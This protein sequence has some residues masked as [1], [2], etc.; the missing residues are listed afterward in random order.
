MFEHSSS[1]GQSGRHPSSGKPCGQRK[2]PSRR[3]GGS[4]GAPPAA[5]LAAPSPSC[6]PRS[7]WEEFAHRHGGELARCVAAAMR[8]V[9]WPA[10]PV[11]LEELVQEVYCRLLARRQPPGLEGWLPS[12]LWGYLHRIVRSTVVDALRARAA[13]KRGGNPWRCTGRD[14]EEGSPALADPRAPGQ[15]AEERL[16]AREAAAALRRRVCELGG[17]EHGPRNLRILELA[18]VEGCTAAEISHRLAGALS[19]SSVHTVLHRLRLQLVA[20]PGAELLAGVG[21]QQPG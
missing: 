14:D 20:A 6:Q 13:R 21:G 8:R 3:R 10:A 2:A 19:P 17:V 18:A 9:G 4:S 11:E 7:C 12:Q 15:T 5:Q 1:S 16:L